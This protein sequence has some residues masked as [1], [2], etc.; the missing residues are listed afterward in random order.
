[1]VNGRGW[2]LS[3]K[4]K[5]QRVEVFGKK[6]VVWDDPEHYIEITQSPAYKRGW[7]I[8]IFDK[9]EHTKLELTGGYGR[10]YAVRGLRQA[11]E[12]AML[13]A[14]KDTANDN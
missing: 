4:R 12:K 14:G 8:T 5:W 1:M 3:V 10:Q 6:L 11:K 13:L 2:E 9:A 7:N